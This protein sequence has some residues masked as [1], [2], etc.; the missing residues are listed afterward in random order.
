MSQ[1]SIKNISDAFLWIKEK[2]DQGGNSTEDRGKE[3]E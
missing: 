1:H 2:E 3:K